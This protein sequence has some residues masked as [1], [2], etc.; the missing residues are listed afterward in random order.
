MCFLKGKSFLACLLGDLPL[1][2]FSLLKHT[3]SEA[4][5]RGAD[6][7]LTPSEGMSGTI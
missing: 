1:T 7:K 2:V 3:Q 5:E 4:E 6:K